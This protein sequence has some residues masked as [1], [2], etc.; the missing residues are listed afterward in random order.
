VCD[1]DGHIKRLTPVSEARL[2]A[3]DAR[4]RADPEVWA[5]W[6][7]VKPNRFGVFEQSALHVVFQFPLRLSSHLESEYFANWTHWRP[8]VE[9]IIEDVG[10]SFQYSGGRTARVMLAKLK[11]GAEIGRHIDQSPSAA[12]PH[13]I[14]VPI[15]TSPEVEFWE[16][17]D[18]YHLERGWAY[19]VNNRIPHGGCNPTSQDRVHLIF[20]YFDPAGAPPP[21]PGLR[22]RRE[23]RLGAD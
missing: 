1:F 5:R 17:N 12:V 2:D 10:G 13:K 20:D 9:P 7:A 22:R 19:E 16:R 4:L 15:R 14:H 21:P 23:R 8:L 6:D 18:T 3:I 11:A